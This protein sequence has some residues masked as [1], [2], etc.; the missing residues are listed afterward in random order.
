[1]D[2]SK[3]SASVDTLSEYVAKIQNSSSQ[4]RDH[5]VT[6]SHVLLSCKLNVLQDPFAFDAEPVPIETPDYVHEVKACSESDLYFL[7]W[8]FEGAFTP[9]TAF[10]TQYYAGYKILRAEAEPG[11][12]WSE[13]R[14]G[15]RG[16]LVWLVKNTIKE[17]PLLALQNILTKSADDTSHSDEA[18]TQKLVLAKLIG[19]Q[20]ELMRAQTH[21]FKT[22]MKNYEQEMGLIWKTVQESDPTIV[23]LANLQLATADVPELP[24]PSSSKALGSK[25]LAKSR[26]RGNQSGGENASEWSVVDEDEE[27]ELTSISGYDTTSDG[28]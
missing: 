27:G 20:Y 14:E 25:S 15:G 6:T 24:R 26:S 16:F 5:S 8:V 7:R 18:N 3:R 11:V 12:N 22:A 4:D 28:E 17:T 1:M 9:L 21:Q 19:A 2:Q 13:F 10:I 23:N